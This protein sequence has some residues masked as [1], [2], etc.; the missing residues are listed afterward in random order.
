MTLT[1]TLA[2]FTFPGMLI[3]FKIIKPDVLLDVWRTDQTCGMV[4][5]SL[6]HNLKPVIAI[7]NLIAIPFIVIMPGVRV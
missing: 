6:G 3:K 4:Q 7:E 1:T 5:N 2:Y